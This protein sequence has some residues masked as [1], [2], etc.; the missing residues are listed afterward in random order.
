MKLAITGASGL[1]GRRIIREFSC[2]DFEL[3]CL[4]RNKQPNDNNYVKWFTGD[5]SVDGVAEELLK[6]QQVLIHL[7]HETKPLSV[8]GRVSHD[9]HNSIAPSLKLIQAI[10][11]RSKPL[12]M[13]YFSS[14]GAIYGEPIVPNRPNYETD[15]CHPPTEYGIQKLVIERYLHSASKVG[16]LRCT[17]LRVSNVYGELLDSNRM[18]GLIGTSV[19]RALAGK[20][21][22]LIGNPH[23][24]RDYIHLS[25]V[26]SV[27]KQVICHNGVFDIFNIGS[28]L[29]YSVLDVLN[30]ILKVTGN[31]CNIETLQIPGD[32][33]LPLWNVLD[34]T[35]V[36]KEFKWCPTISLEAGI[37]SL[38]QSP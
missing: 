12:H 25:D 26:M 16:D 11:A 21:L 30:I 9:L 20:P 33:L 18:Q 14:G 8:S 1:I 28:G 31:N 34:I 36:M 6:D 2:G 15:R 7:A 38:C 29:G 5:L 17:I 3:T 32:T 4:S 13:I 10:K 35:K 23:N 37:Q 27:L 24:V 22:R 19:T